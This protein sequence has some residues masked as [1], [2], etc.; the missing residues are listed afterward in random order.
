MDLGVRTRFVSQ[1]NSRGKTTPRNLVEETSA[2]LKVV[3]VNKGDLV[4][5]AGN[6]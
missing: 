5:M 2:S 6:G 4:L 1:S 3:I